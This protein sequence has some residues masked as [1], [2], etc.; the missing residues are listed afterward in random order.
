MFLRLQFPVSPDSIIQIREP[1]FSLQDTR[2]VVTGMTKGRRVSPIG[3]GMHHYEAFRDAFHQIYTSFCQDL[4]GRCGGKTLMMM[5]AFD[6]KVK[7]SE[8]AEAKEEENARPVRRLAAKSKESPRD[9]LRR[10]GQRLSDRFQS[11]MKKETKDNGNENK[12]EHIAPLATTITTI[13]CI[14]ESYH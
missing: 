9:R 8:S 13:E 2:L 1:F 3:D 11:Q 14:L 5:P 4:V 6:C 10:L 7:V 12:R